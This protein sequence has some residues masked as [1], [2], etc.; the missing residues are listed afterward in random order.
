[1]L[2]SQTRQH[3]RDPEEVNRVSHQLLRRQTRVSCSGW[4][5]WC[6]C[7][8]H[9]HE[10]DGLFARY[11]LALRNGN[12]RQVDVLQR[13]IQKLQDTLGRRA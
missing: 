4:K 6:V 10:S 1:M 8:N 11:R 7:Q 9:L 12:E 2:A 5:F 3:R 13:E